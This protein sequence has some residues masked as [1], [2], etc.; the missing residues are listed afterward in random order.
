MDTEPHPLP[1]PCEE[2]GARRCHFPLSSQGGQGVG[3][4]ET[5]L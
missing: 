4:R 2:R 5:H 1:L 3:F